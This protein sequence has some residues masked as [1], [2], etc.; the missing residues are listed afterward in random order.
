VAILVATIL[1]GAGGL[2]VAGEEAHRLTLPDTR[3]AALSWVIENIPAGSGVVEEQGGPDLYS[4]EL[5]PLAPEPTYRLVEITPMFSRGGEEKDPLDRLV[6]AR[7]EWVIT[8]SRVRDRYMRPGAEREFPELV[9]AFKIYYSLI[10]GYLREVA[11]FTPGRGTEG[12]Q[13][14]V[15]RVPE[16]FW[17]RVMVGNTT[18]GEALE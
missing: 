11:R 15:Y 18:V 9:A 16:G 8:S 1:I 7:P 12:P 3:E 14:A 17:D 4:T 6:A 13:I 5:A 10:D 2:I